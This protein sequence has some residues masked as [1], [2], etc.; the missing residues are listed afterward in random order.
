[1]PANY[2]AGLQNKRLNEIVIPGSHDA[3]IYGKGKKNIV[4][5]SLNIAQQ[6][7]VGVRWYD[8]RIATMKTSTGAF[9]QRSF[10]LTS[11]LVIGKKKDHQNVDHFGGWG[12][13]T[14]G[15]M[16]TQAKDFVKA[17]STE[18]LILKFSKSYNLQG[19]VD[20]CVE[21]L[22]EYQ[23]KR[24]SKA[25][26]NLMRV[27]DLAGKVITLFDEKDIAKLNLPIGDD[28]YLG[29]K[30]YR[31]LY[32]SDTKTS[33]VY[34]K[35]FDGLQYFGK[36]S[37]TP[38]VDVN[39]KKQNDILQA[40]AMGADRDAMGMMYWTLTGTGKHLTVFRSIKSRDK[41]LWTNNSVQ[42]LNETWENGL[43]QAIRAQMGRDF[44]Y[45]IE[46]RRN[47]FKIGGGGTWKAFMPN[48]V[49]MD[50]A[51]EKKCETILELNTI[52]NTQINN[53]VNM[54]MQDGLL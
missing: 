29:I 41:G 46:H 4:T 45:A 54:F 17:Y 15:K 50:F 25:N 12:S 3:G 8:L 1:M 34:D 37:N 28:R 21:V 10:H 20:A 53:Y 24:L 23:Y 2:L 6:A 51:D 49:M 36:Y 18:F 48:I 9:E 47:K 19:V 38:E 39:T 35:T 7:M 16:L 30:K 42:S 11:P 33:K 52:A 31:E 32:D 40:G 5:Q 27:G 26:L 22:G 43:M 13:D 44:Q 14:L